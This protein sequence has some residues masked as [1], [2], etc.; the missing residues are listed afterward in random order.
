VSELNDMTAGP[1]G[2]APPG[3]PRGRNSSIEELRRAVADSSPV[4][5]LN[6]MTAGPAGGAPPGLPRGR[7]ASIEELRRAV[8]DYIHT[9]LG[10]PRALEPEA[11]EPGGTFLLPA[12]R[13]LREMATLRFRLLQR[14]ATGADHLAGDAERLAA[15]AARG[16]VPWDLSA[17]TVTTLAKLLGRVR[18][19]DDL[20]PKVAGALVDAAVAAGVI[21]PRPPAAPP[22]ADPG[23][24]R[25]DTGRFGDVIA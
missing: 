8:A 4:S 22:P 10:V 25:E 21:E 20:L 5:E 14:V 16:Q 24:L 23:P 17:D 18:S 11:L 1:A 19:L 12:A 6:D 9:Q 3:L 13:L 7:P 15:E 2:G